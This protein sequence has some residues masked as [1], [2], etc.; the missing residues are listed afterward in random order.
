MTRRSLA[1]FALALVVLGIAGGPASAKRSKTMVVGKDAAGDWS[2][3]I[4]PALAPLGDQLGQDLVSATIDATS[5]TEI[6]FVF[7]LTSLPTDQAPA[8]VLVW[9]FTI[10]DKWWRLTNALCD[11]SS[12]VTGT[13]PAVTPNPPTSCVPE[14]G[15]G[16]TFELME[17]GDARVVNVFA[18]CLARESVQA[19]LDAGAGTIS[20]SVSRDA[21]GAVKGSRIGPKDFP[22]GPVAARPAIPYSG[23]QPFFGDQLAITKTFFVP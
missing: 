23:A 16:A 1:L 7:G 5:P 12:T 19:E 15:V 14:P 2:K 9:D 17:C 3:D 22:F 10:G 8:S 20:V 11:P 4:N 21:I 18:N 13:P 6:A